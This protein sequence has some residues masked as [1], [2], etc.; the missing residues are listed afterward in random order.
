MHRFS[1]TIRDN[2]AATLANFLSRFLPR[3][4]IQ[5]D[6]RICSNKR[7]DVLLPRA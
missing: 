3:Y 4:S 2:A 7:T 6:V 1:D 5:Y